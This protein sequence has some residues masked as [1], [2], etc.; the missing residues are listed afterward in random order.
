MHS[1]SQQIVSTK[2]PSPPFILL[3]AVWLS[4]L[5]LLVAAIGIIYM[6]VQTQKLQ[7]VADG[8]GDIDAQLERIGSIV[9]RID[10]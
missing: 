1:S 10:R 6:A 5:S 7:S 9:A 2:Q 3:A 4:A 8:L